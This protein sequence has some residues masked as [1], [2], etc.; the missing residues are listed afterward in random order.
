MDRDP[1]KRA[2]FFHGDTRRCIC[3]FHFLGNTKKPLSVLIV[4]V[5]DEKPLCARKQ[6]YLF[7]YIRLKAAVRLNVLWRY[8]RKDRPGK[9]DEPGPRCVNAFRCDLY[10]CIPASGA[11]GIMQKT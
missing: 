5:D 9:P 7:P 3:I 8:I 10:D 4:S 2:C 11:R 1:F 6:F